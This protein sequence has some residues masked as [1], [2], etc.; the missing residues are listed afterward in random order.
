MAGP[1]AVIVGHCLTGLPKDYLTRQNVP[2]SD[3]AIQHLN[4]GTGQLID[5]C[6]VE[7]EY[8]NGYGFITLEDMNQLYIYICM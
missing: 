2:V 3:F 7:T 8:L 1:Y 4:K 5:L 6:P